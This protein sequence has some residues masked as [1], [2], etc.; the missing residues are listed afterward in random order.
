MDDPSDATINVLPAFISYTP[1]SK[2]DAV[3]PSFAQATRKSH[4]KSRRGCHTCKRR[5]IK[6]PENRPSCVNCI[7]ISTPCTYGPDKPAIYQTAKYSH[8]LTSNESSLHLRPSL[9]STPGE[10]SLTDLRLF[11]HFIITCFP[12]LPLGNSKV[13]VTSIASFSHSYDFLVHSLLALSAS[14]LSFTSTSDLQEVGLSHRLVAIR[15]LNEALSRPPKT[16][17]DADAMLAT[18]YALAMQSS[19]IGESVEEFLTMIRGCQMIL[20]QQWPNQLG[21]AFQHL[22]QESQLQI[23]SSKVRFLPDIDPESIVLGTRSLEALGPLCQQPL[24]RK[25]L[26]Y[27]LDIVKS[28]AHS[29]R[30]GWLPFSTIPYNP[31][32]HLGSKTRTSGYFDC[33]NLCSSLSSLPHA[34]FQLLVSPDNPVMQILLGHFAAIMVLVYPVKSCDWTNENWGTPNREA[35]FQ[36]DGIFKNLPIGMQGYLDWPRTITQSL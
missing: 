26:R 21:T 33:A 25:V 6:C 27:L 4:T 14:H 36:L 5:K 31:P 29:S 2:G 20:D 13:W 16:S 22:D 1:N 18:C 30:D 8:L 35:V 32:S 10:F 9:Q 12:H 24:E 17:A 19:Y 28:L 34:E 15:G 11:H 7:K 3:H 23:V